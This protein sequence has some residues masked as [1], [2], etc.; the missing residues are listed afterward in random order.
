MK[1]PHGEIGDNFNKIGEGRNAEQF[2]G[3]VAELIESDFG[4]AI[5]KHTQTCNVCRNLQIAMGQI[6]TEHIKELGEFKFD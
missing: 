2:Q 3:R 4:L 6:I 1:E 5:V